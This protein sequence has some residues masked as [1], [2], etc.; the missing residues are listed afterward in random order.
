MYVEIWEF[1]YTRDVVVG[2]KI[3]R[4]E[5]ELRVK[6][7]GQGNCNYYSYELARSLS[8]SLF[9]SRGIWYATNG[10]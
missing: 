4:V 8:L 9:W 2:M 7:E 3:T 10:G 1:E 6:I 5:A